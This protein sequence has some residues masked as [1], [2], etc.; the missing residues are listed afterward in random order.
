MKRN[1]ILLLT[2]VLILFILSSCL[3]GGG[4]SSPDN[5]AGFF[6]GIWHGWIAP[7]SLIMGI[8][9]SSITI[10]ESFNTGWWYDF[11]F[12][13]SII[14]GFGSLQLFRKKKSS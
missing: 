8:F 7:F 13:M 10:Y 4:S 12:Y 14:A 9:N 11:G 6:T 2:S 3:P 5:P 1:Q